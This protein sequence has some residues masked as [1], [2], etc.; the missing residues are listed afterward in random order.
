L[1]ELPK[2]LS[3]QQ[4]EFWEHY[5]QSKVTSLGT[6]H[7]QPAFKTFLESANAVPPGKIA[8]LGCGTGHD[9]ILIFQSWFYRDGFDFAPSAVAAVKVKF[10]KTGILNERGFVVQKDIF[11][12][13]DFNG[14][15]DYVSRAH[16]FLCES[17]L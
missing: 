15:F 9:C 7:A 6:G 8:A 10:E 2:D 13:N 11:D 14:Q 17:I 3:V 1:A 12:L 5:Y 16:L 4:V